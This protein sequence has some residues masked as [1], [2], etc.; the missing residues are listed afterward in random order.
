MTREFGDYA[1]GEGFPKDGA[2]PTWRVSA[3]SHLALHCSKLPHC[4]MPSLEGNAPRHF[5]AR[6]PGIRHRGQPFLPEEGA[7]RRN[8]LSPAQGLNTRILTMLCVLFH[9]DVHARRVSPATPLGCLHV[10]TDSR[11]WCP[12]PEETSASLLLRC[13]HTMVAG[14]SLTNRTFVF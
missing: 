14:S 12:R 5:L 9:L 8:P 3:P 1:Q 2:S 10:Q 6:C 4:L 13:L 7:S 11:A